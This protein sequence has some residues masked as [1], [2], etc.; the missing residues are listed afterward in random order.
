LIGT[1]VP[2][3]ANDG[4]PIKLLN[5]TNVNAALPYNATAW[6]GE[7]DFRAKYKELWGIK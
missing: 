6:Q 4:V 5:T 3:A 7:Y 2:P 1:P